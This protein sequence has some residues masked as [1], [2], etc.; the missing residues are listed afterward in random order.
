MKKRVIIIIALFLALD[1]LPD[2]LKANDTCEKMELQVSYTLMESIQMLISDI[3]DIPLDSILPESDFYFDFGF[4]WLDLFELCSECEDLY[5][6]TITFEEIDELSTVQD[7]H[8]L[9]L[10]KLYLPRCL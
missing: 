5:D 9:I 3:Y 10:P 7:L 1:L 4:D 2:K 8:D 6:V